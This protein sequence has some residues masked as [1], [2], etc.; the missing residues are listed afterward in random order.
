MPLDFLRTTLGDAVVTQVV[1]LEIGQQLAWLLPQTTPENIRQITWLGAPFRNEDFSLNAVSQCFIIEIN[2]RILVVDTCIGNDK[3]I[4]EVAEWNGQRL[5]FLET[6]RSAGIDRERVTDVICTHLHIDHVGW[7]TY[8]SEGEW[9]PTFPNAKYHFARGEYEYW[10]QAERETLAEKG[11]AL[12]SESVLPVFDAGLAHLIEPPTDLG[13][14]ITIIPTP[15]HTHSHIAIEINAG[16]QSFIIAGDAFHHPC[17]I[18]KPEW[19][20]IGD[21]DQ[22]QSTATRQSLLKELT[23]SATLIAGTHFSPPSFGHI[24]KS[25][26]GDYRF[27]VSD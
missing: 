12:M 13:D 27:V 3:K 16:A 25:S 4:S 21:Y 7:N 8:L 1:E 9:L 19:A 24:I 18:A 23:G 15:G 5:G 6:L 14:G 11:S 22:S 10:L 20:S 26:T 2:G 17:Q